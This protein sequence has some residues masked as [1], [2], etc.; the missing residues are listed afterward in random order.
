MGALV[1]I[2][3]LCMLHTSWYMVADVWNRRDPFL[4][5]MWWGSWGQLGCE[6]TNRQM[7]GEE[8]LVIFQTW[9]LW[10]VSCKYTFISYLFLSVVCVTLIFT[11]YALHYIERYTNVALKK[12]IIHWVGLG[13]FLELVWHMFQQ[14]SN[15][16]GCRIG[17]NPGRLPCI[18][19]LPNIHGSFL[20]ALT[21]CYIY[22]LM[23][24]L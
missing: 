11:L 24:L 20:T 3:V 13:I 7:L 16:I 6:C 22:F 14:L 4:H 10:G 9:A 2:F 15:A 17:R 1:S 23:G 8:K 12:K 21:I 19:V 5:K 18:P